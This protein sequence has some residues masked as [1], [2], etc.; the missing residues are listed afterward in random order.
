MTIVISS[1]GRALALST[2]NA[3]NGMIG[4][5][6]VS[7]AEAM[8]EVAEAAEN[9]TNVVLHHVG[10]DSLIEGIPFTIEND[11]AKIT[12]LTQIFVRPQSLEDSWLILE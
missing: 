5:S 7:T 9:G 3:Q 8:E 1:I 4:W 10:T 6:R 11:K 2:N 12:D